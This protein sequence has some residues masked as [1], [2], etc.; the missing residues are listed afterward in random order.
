MTICLIYHI[1]ATSTMLHSQSEKV[2]INKMD[3]NTVPVPAPSVSEQ[4]QKSKDISALE[5]VIDMLEKFLLT[6]T[7]RTQ[8]RPKQQPYSRFP[9]IEGFD[10]LPCAICNDAAHSALTPCREH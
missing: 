6:N 2:S 3:V 5:K 1:T 8:S 10:D 4:Q 7:H 9:R